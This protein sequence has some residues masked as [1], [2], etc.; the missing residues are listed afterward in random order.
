MVIGLTCMQ[1]AEQLM[2]H[3]Y[4]YWYLSIR[5][6]KVNKRFLLILFILSL[7]FKQIISAENLRK[8]AHQFSGFAWFDRRR[9]VYEQNL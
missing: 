2:L 7:N 6:K 8:A 9:Y 4:I 1:V 3:L 5:Q